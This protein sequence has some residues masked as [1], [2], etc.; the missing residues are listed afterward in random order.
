M[1][2]PEWLPEDWAVEHTGT[3][4]VLRG[5]VV[6]EPSDGSEYPY[7]GAPVRWQTVLE[8]HADDAGRFVVV[9][10]QIVNDEPDDWPDVEWHRTL[11]SVR[12]H[13]IWATGDME[14]EPLTAEQLADEAAMYAYFN[15]TA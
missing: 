12:E 9:C 2:R 14:A 15:G 6:D 8:L 7:D 1:E 13:L 3:A 11:A 4:D 5:P 10:A